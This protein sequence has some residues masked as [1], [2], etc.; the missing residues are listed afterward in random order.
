MPDPR[1][2][3]NSLIGLV[4]VAHALLTAPLFRRWYN[5]AG[6]TPDEVG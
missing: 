5:S 3:A 4:R 6:A 2:H 1:F